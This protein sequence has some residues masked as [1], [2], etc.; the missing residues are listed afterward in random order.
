MS[1]P[2][3]TATEIKAGALVKLGVIAAGET[4]S[5]ADDTLAGEA[6]DRLIDD[7]VAKGEAVY[8]K[9]RIPDHEK[10]TLIIALADDL[11]EAFG[12]QAEDRDRFRI[13]ARDAR[14]ESRRRASAKR[15][16]SIVSFVNY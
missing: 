16:R 13:E 7:M 1:G 2:T 3:A 14:H 9:A 12:I 4:A 5:A 8:D 15:A 11:A 6:L 10:R